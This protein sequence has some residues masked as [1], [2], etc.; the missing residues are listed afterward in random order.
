MPNTDL[1]LAEQVL[2]SCGSSGSCAGGYID[3]ASDYL[4]DMGLPLE[5]CYPYT[6][7][8]GRCNN[9]CANWTASAYKTQ[10]WSWVATHAPTVDA[11]KTALNTYGP[12]VTTMDVYADFFN[13]ASGIYSYV[14]GSYQGGH[15]VLLVGYDDP[16]QYFIVKNSWGIYWGE[17]GYFRIAYSQLASVVD[18]GWWTIAYQ[19]SAPPPPPA[20]TAVPSAATTVSPSGTITTAT[21]TY[22]WNAV[23]CSSDYYLWV[24]DS[25]GIRIQQW[26]TAADAGCASGTGTCSVT[27]STTLNNGAARWWIQTCWGDA[28]YG[29]WSAGMDYTVNMGCTAVPSATTIVFPSGTITTATPTYTWNAVPCSSWYYLWVDDSAGTRIQQWYTAADAGCASGTGTCS[30]TPS[31]TLNNGAARWWI[32]TWDDAGYGPWSA[33]MGFRVRP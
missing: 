30:V 4:R 2:L 14:S 23:P 19:N 32:Q 8:D 17:A 27:P 7:T 11:L 22:R 18:F 3:R 28:G 16:G 29:P 21:P 12:L 26:Y 1:N 10:G 13:Y 24:E 20:C 33:G 15:A 6:G 25:T 9:A 31:T 5:T